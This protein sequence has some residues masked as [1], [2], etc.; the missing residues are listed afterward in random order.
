LSGIIA[1]SSAM[2]N[3]AGTTELDTGDLNLNL[4]L[5]QADLL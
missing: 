3:A 4:A 5:R 1:P 2:L